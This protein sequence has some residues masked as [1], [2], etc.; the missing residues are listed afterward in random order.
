LIGA[1]GKAGHLMI[2]IVG[3]ARGLKGHVR[4]RSVTDDPERFRGL[5]KAWFLENGKY[6][7]VE[8]AED[9]VNSVGVHLRFSGVE[10]R[11]AADRLSGRELYVKRQDAVELP[12]GA[13]FIADVIGC[14]VEDGE[15]NA[16]GKVADVLQS[17]AAD[18]YVLTGGH[19]GQVLFPALKTVIRL[20]DTDAGRIVVDAK[21]FKEV[22]VFED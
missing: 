11:A 20:T 21:R 4:V 13:H 15:G 3:R 19:G 17:G 7:P 18:V 14:S 6:V 8:I 22:A 10:D 9:E 5:K 16:L 1:E 12:A 2:G